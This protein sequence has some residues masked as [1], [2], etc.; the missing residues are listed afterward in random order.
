MKAL[1]RNHEDRYQTVQEMQHDVELFLRGYGRLT[2][3]FFPKGTQIIRDGDEGEKAYMLVRGRCLAYKEID[4]KRKKL[5]EMNPGDVFGEVAA[6]SSRIRTANVEALED[7]EVKVI[8]KNVLDQEFGFGSWIN[9]VLKALATRFSG[10]ANEN[11]VFRQ[12][13]ADLHLLNQIQLQLT[14]D[15][16]RNPQGMVEGSWSQLC[17]TLIEQLDCSK[18]DLTECVSTF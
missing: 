16:T 4:G 6:F 14:L 5:H 15:G 1:Q 2:N 9:R 11:L 17:Q 18:K 13:V 12:E 3:Q 10:I 8:D 7:V